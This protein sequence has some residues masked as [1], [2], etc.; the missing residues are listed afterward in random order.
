MKKENVSLHDNLFDAFLKH[1]FW[2]KKLYMFLQMEC[3]SEL[4]S[5]RRLCCYSPKTAYLSSFQACMSQTQSAQMEREVM[6]FSK[7]LYNLYN[8]APPRSPPFDSLACLDTL[9]NPLLCLTFKLPTID[10]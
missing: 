3:R 2:C 6:P 5:V 8:S 7:R 4:P 1:F 10:K 9:L